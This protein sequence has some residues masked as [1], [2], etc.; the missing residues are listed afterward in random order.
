[1][2]FF[3][4]LFFSF[5]LL[6]KNRV[7]MQKNLWVSEFLGVKNQAVPKTAPTSNP[8]PQEP[9][10]MRPRNALPQGHIYKHNYF[11]PERNNT[12]ENITWV[13]GK[14]R[15]ANHTYA[16]APEVKDTEVKTIRT[17]QL[18]QKNL[19]IFSKTTEM[20][21]GCKSTTLPHG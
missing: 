13:L 6:I 10:K 4:F 2:V 8:L 5:C 12:R 11:K 15:T 3:V 14:A 7:N 19:F 21:D 16:R 9:W 20:T 1:M 17:L 18:V